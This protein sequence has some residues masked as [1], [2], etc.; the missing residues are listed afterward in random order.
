MLLVC[1]S[2][3]NCGQATLRPLLSPGSVL[4]ETSSGLETRLDSPSDTR[5]GKFSFPYV[6]GLESIKNGKRLWDVILSQNMKATVAHPCNKG[7]PSY[8]ISSQRL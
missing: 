3:I 2:G 7:L 4:F 8:K 6:F 1:T 5:I